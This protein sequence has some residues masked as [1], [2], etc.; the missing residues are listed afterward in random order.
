[1]KFKLILIS[2]ITMFATFAQSQAVEF[3]E[4]EHYR[5]IPTRFETSDIN[6]DTVVVTEMFSYICNHCYTFERDLEDWLPKQDHRVKFVRE[7]VIF[8]VTSLSLAKAFYAAE[9]L[10]VTE[11]IHI[12]MFTAIHVNGL[13]MN[14]LDLLVRLFEGRG[15]TS[16]TDFRTAYNSF[17]VENRVRRSDALVRGWRI[18]STP[19]MVVDGRYI[20]G[21]THTRT[22]RQ[23]LDVVDFLVEKVLEDRRSQRN[24]GS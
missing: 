15:E 9:E 10:G 20:A 14:Q 13:R 12:P 2:V 11:K 3:R 19:T 23:I 5:E 18:D 22:N 4:F 8:S 1:M 6:S 16:A 24:T 17:N 7:H 21:G